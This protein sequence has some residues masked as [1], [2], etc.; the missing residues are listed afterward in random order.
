MKQFLII[1]WWEFFRHFKSRSFLL[2]TFISPLVFAFIV[3]LPTLYLEDYS[4]DQLK[5]IGCVAFDS[6]RICRDVQ[7]RFNEMSI[8]SATMPAIHLVTIKTDTSAK[9]KSRFN[10]LRLLKLERDS[11]QD[12]YNTVKERRKY[13]FQKPKTASRE[14]LLKNTYEELVQTREA[15]DLAEL[16]HQRAK[17]LMDSLWR[18]AIVRHADDLLVTLRLEGYLL[19]NPDE[20]VE[21]TVEF[22]S[23]LPSNFLEIEPLKQAVQV[24]IVE[25]RLKKENLRVDKIQEWLSPLKFRE[26]QLQGSEKEEFDFLIN[27][28]GP[29]IVVFFLFISIFTSSGFLFSGVLKEKTNRVIELL[30]SSVNHNQLVAGKIFGLGLLGIFQIMIWYGIT[31]VLIVSNLLNVSEIGFLSLKNAGLFLLYFILG[32]LYFASIFVGIGS[33][34]SNEEDAHHL[35]QFMRMLSI[36]PIVLA[37]LVLETPNSFLVR[38]LSFIPPLT[39]TFMILRIPLGNPPPIDY[40]ISIGIMLLSILISIYFAGKLFRVGSLLYGK[41]P[42]F[43]EIFGVL[44]GRS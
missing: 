42:G 14:A 37:I 16:E 43:K 7:R 44:F 5:R 25:Q 3:F 13:I 30:L 12:A 1:T 32:Y 9:M 2:S 35:N 15:H 22:H 40:Y 8:A 10:N 6:T 39:P 4:H 27:Y 38:I 11:L 34:F 21:G 23:L 31:L 19:I 33:L 28:L 26:I 18:V 41:K 36:L 24:V 20:F 29:I 17:H